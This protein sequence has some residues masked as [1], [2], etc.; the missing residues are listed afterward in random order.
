MK[1]MWRLLFYTLILTAIFVASIAVVRE[2]AIAIPTPPIQIFT[3]SDGSACPQICIYGVQ[4]GQKITVQLAAAT[5]LKHPQLRDIQKLADSNGIVQYGSKTVLDIDIRLGWAGNPRTVTWISALYLK[6]PRHDDLLGRYVEYLA[7]PP[8][9]GLDNISRNM[10]L[11]F[12]DQRLIIQALAVDGY[13][14]GPDDKVYTLT[15][16]DVTSFEDVLAN[17]TLKAWRGFTSIERYYA[18]PPVH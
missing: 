15:L 4:P 11:V 16:Y 17:Y 6:F 1:W 2:S 12:P 13:R 9:I 5:L 18:A 10:I 14:L 3:D 8:L 7:T